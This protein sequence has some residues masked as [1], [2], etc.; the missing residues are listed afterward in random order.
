VGGAICEETGQSAKS[1]V[2][3]REIGEPSRRDVR[4]ESGSGGTGGREPGDDQ[5]LCR[6][7][8]C[9]LTVPERTRPRECVSVCG[10]ATAN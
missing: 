9:E 3:T 7:P 4:F 8:R 10:L 1:R 5:R 2:A 6:K